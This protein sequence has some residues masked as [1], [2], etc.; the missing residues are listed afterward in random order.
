MLKS[1]LGAAIERD[2][3]AAW[4]RTRKMEKEEKMDDVRYD[5]N[6]R[7]NGKNQT[8]SKEDAC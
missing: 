1:S 7:A 8:P 3:H 4:L 2:M 6:E 5:G